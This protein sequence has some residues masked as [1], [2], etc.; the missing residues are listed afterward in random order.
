MSIS[1]ASGMLYPVL[2]KLE[3]EEHSEVSKGKERSPESSR[4]FIAISLPEQVK[5]QIARAQEELRGALSGDSVRWTNRGQLHLTLKFLGAVES[6]RLDELTNAVRGACEGFEV[7]QLR[8][9][10][11]GCF[12]NLSH[13]RVIWARVH[14]E[15]ERLPL[16][17]RAV[18]TATAEFTSERPEGTFTGHVT[19][20]RCQAINRRQ[21]ELLAKLARAMEPGLFGEWT[22]NSVE[23]IRSELASGGSHYTP[24]AAA[25]LAATFSSRKLP[26]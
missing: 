7:L 11:I 10:Q 16:L 8:A 9:E 2:L 22:A 5:D 4:I 14:D 21:A 3:Q 15:K 19:L 23:I 6:R 12:P 1:I 25:P 24:L 18:E 20:G 13:P 17:Q 26:Q